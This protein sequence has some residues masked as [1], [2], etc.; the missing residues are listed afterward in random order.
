MIL[1][2]FAFPILMK[3]VPTSLSKIADH[4]RENPSKSS[5]EVIR[6]A[7]TV[8]TDSCEKWLEREWEVSIP[9]LRLFST[10]RP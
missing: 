10:N 8:T 1:I 5:E 7:D 3:P 6:I 4:C 9:F 2:R